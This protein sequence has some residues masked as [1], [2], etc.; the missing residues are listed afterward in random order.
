MLMAPSRGGAGGAD[1]TSGLGARAETA[2]LQAL[3]AGKTGIIR[4]IRTGITTTRET[5]TGK[6]SL[7]EG[8]TPR[9]GAAEVVNAAGAQASLID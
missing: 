5:G 7:A 9:G 3:Q 2:M 1:G 6:M 4:G 8:D